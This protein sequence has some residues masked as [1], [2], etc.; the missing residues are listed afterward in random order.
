M[1]YLSLLVLAV[2][3]LQAQHK[4]KGVFKD[5]I[6]N[7]RNV[8]LYQLVNG[9]SKYLKYVAIKDN[10]FVFEM[11]SLQQGYYRALYQNI[12]TGYVDF[13][14]NKESIDFEVDSKKGQTSVAYLA[15]REN[16]LLQAYNYNIAGL[17]QKLD[18]IQLAFFKKPSAE[19]AKYKEVQT[20]IDGAQSY[21]EDLAKNDYCIHFIKAS[22]RFNAPLPYTLP[23]N[24]IKSIKEH[25]F[26]AIDFN[27]KALLNST[28]LKKKISDYVFYLHQH[29]DV[30]TQNTLLIGAIDTVLAKTTTLALKES[31]LRFL[32]KKLIV[33][34]LKDVTYDAL[35]IYKKLPEAIQDTEMLQKATQQSKTL[36]GAVAPDIK[37]SETNSLH[38]LKEHEKYVV[39]FWSSTCSHCRATLPKV[40]NF[41]SDKQ[42]LKV[43][44]VGIENKEDKQSWL[45]NIKF[46]P[47]WEN[48][49][50]LGKWESKDALNYNIN[51]TPSFFL[52]D[53]NKII[54]AKPN[55]LEELKK[56]F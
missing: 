11:D 43:I 51:G 29:K 38:K 47:D 54:I 52:L 34:E 12:P 31:V 6:S 17:Q 32:I 55:D 20:K 30:A 9:E 16:Q 25:F 15:S 4:V 53:K 24:Y 35:D 56:L 27:E 8:A 7:I 36:L 3:L 18:S 40:N 39:I 26:D 22:K 33:K 46:Y 1:K 5:S 49:L 21:Y 14:Y 37:I 41:L 50:S 10:A 19:V 48:V 45:N 42:G 28:F 2:N 23:G 44:A 13:I